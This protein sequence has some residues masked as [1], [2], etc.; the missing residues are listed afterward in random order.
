MIAGLVIKP[1]DDKIVKEEPLEE[2]IAPPEEKYE[3][4]NKLRKML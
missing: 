3:I 1:N 2:I 4:L